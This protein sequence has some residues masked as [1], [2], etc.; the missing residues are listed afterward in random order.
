[1]TPGSARGVRWR[2]WR[3]QRTDGHWVLESGT[4]LSEGAEDQRR[5][6][7]GGSRGAVWR[8]WRACGSLQRLCTWLLWEVG[9]L[10]TLPLGRHDHMRA[11]S[12]EWRW[13]ALGWL[14]R[15][16]IPEVSTSQ[17]AVGALGHL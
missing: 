9:S 12:A 4:P 1:M 16:G 13:A 17:C 7:F 5:G 3:C 6:D 15:A 14:E 10:Y 2:L 11:E 8:V